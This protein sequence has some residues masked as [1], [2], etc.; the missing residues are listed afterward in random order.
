M[1]YEI[2]IENHDLKIEDDAEKRIFSKLKYGVLELSDFWEINENK[3]VPS[4]YSLKWGDWFEEDLKNM[5]K[6]G[7]TGFIEV[8]GEQGECSKF[9]LRD[10]R[11]EVFYGRVVYS[12]K[13]DE[14]LE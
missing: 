7:V 5:A 3:I 10:E 9:V 2:I 13:P 14:I 1:G 4:E 6:M 11:V 12:E 8:R